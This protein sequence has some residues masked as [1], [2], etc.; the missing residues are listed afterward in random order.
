MTR[1]L[2]LRTEGGGTM[3]RGGIR[4]WLAWGA[5]VLGAL[6]GAYLG[7]EQRRLDARLAVV[8]AA[9]KERRPCGVADAV[10][11][12][13]A[14][15]ALADEAVREARAAVERQKEELEGEGGSP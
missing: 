11:R 13:V 3:R 9:L 7:V 2:G 4:V 10:E 6:A 5:V 1:T 12:A 8:E 14:V 15:V